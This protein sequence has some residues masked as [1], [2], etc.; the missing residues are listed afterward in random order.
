MEKRLQGNL[1]SAV[2]SFGDLIN[3]WRNQRHSCQQ[4]LQYLHSLIRTRFSVYKTLCVGSR[5]KRK[6]ES[7]QFLDLPERLDAQISMEIEKTLFSIKEAL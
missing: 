1:K 2:K 3:S 4:Y 7:V 5:W 6:F